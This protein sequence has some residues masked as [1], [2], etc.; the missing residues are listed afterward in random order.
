M[1]KQPAEAYNGYREPGIRLMAPLP[2]AQAG[3]RSD[4][5]AP[6]IRAVHEFDKAHALML[7]EAELAPRP[8]AAQMLR[9]LTEIEASGME[10]ARA[11]AGGGLH[12]GEHL[13]IRRHGEEVG[14]WLSLGRSS[15]DLGV[16]CTRMLQRDALLGIMTAL[17]LLRGAALTLAD[18]HLETVL[19]GL[20]SGRHGQPVTLGHQYAAWG[21]VFAR[22]FARVMQAYERI[23]ESPAG[24]GVMAGSGLA[25]E[26]LRV[27]ELL[28]F[29]RPIMNTLDAVMSRDTVLDS[30]AVLTILNGNVQ[31]LADDILLWSRSEYGLA[32]VPD[33]FCATSSIMPQSRNPGVLR[34]TS[35]VSAASLGGFA[36]A[37]MVEKAATGENVV[38]RSYE[39]VAL[40][41]LHGDTIRDLRVMAELLPRM[42]WDTERMAAEAAAGWAVATDVAEALVR[43]GLPWRSAHQITGILV[44]LS[45][46]RDIAPVDVTVKLVDE[47]AVEYM[48]EP[49]GLSAEALSRALDPRHFVAVRGQGGP[50]PDDVR[51][52]LQ[53]LRAQLEADR[54]AHQAAAGRVEAAA[55]RLREGVQTVVDSSW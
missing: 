12:S 46:E 55:T 16:L 38:E 24:A 45:E 21:A 25:V 37:A 22:D 9:T 29:D 6:L 30:F 34:L 50:A 26:R 17:N 18:D 42:R 41:R 23:N 15:N 2:P 19:P 3:Q 5:A 47:A 48:D 28:G 54:G 32:E 49:I 11:E 53:H 20:L 51:A 39:I 4:L 35:G 7:F 27:S 36:T 33:E 31:R 8:A 14:G 40:D 13:L 43:T 1:R 44:R 10:A 52:Q